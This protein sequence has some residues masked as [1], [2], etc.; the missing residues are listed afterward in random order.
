MYSEVCPEFLTTSSL[1]FETSTICTKTNT[2]HH[3]QTGHHHRVP[4]EARQTDRS[5]RNYPPIKTPHIYKPEEPN[6][7]SV[8]KE[9]ARLSISSGCLTMWCLDFLWIPSLPVVRL[10]Y[11]SPFKVGNLT[12]NDKDTKEDKTNYGFVHQC[13]VYKTLHTSKF[14]AR[15]V[16]KSSSY[17]EMRG[18][19]LLTIIS[20][21]IV[22]LHWYRKC[23]LCELMLEF[24]T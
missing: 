3:F 6:D 8:L 20:L 11:F 2:E 4:T 5:L 16:E 15:R 13:C 21:C 9:Q 14:K 10:Q 23:M 7:R 12:K 1:L 22:N 24:S 17:P 19:I 18:G